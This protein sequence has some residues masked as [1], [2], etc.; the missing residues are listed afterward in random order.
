MEQW[1]K[2]RHFSFM[3]SGHYFRETDHSGLSV[4]YACVVV[5]SCAAIFLLRFRTGG[6]HFI[7]YCIFVQLQEPNTL[8]QSWVRNISVL[9][10]ILELFNNLLPGQNG[11][12]I[13]NDLFLNS[14]HGGNHFPLL[15]KIFF[16]H[17]YKFSKVHIFWEG[18]KILRNLHQLFVLCTASQIFGGDFA[19]FSRMEG[20]QNKFF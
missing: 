11:I 19:K 5:E 9:H 6:C 20:F 17:N 18:H 2:T 12:C 8:S 13:S 4:Y 10:T 7:W 3:I 16:A 15:H 1:R 14:L